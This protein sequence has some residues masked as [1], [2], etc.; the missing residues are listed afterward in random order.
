M[1]W[2]IKRIIITMK[3]ILNKLVFANLEHPSDHFSQLQ[4]TQLRRNY[5]AWV[6]KQKK[7][8]VLL[9][10]DI[11]DSSFRAQTK[12]LIRSAKLR[13]SQQA[14]SDLQTFKIRPWQRYRLA[15]RGYLFLLRKKKLQRPESEAVEIFAFTFAVCMLFVKTIQTRQQTFFSSRRAGFQ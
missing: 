10:F 6:T 1:R 14:N 9:L 12:S 13:N 4:L 8:L 7:I 3:N 5:A 11:Y 2:S 15:N